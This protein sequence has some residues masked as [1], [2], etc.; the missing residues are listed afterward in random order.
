MPTVSIPIDVCRSG[1]TLTPAA[2]AVLLALLSYGGGPRPPLA[3]VAM[4]AGVSLRHLYRVMA[5]LR[6]GGFLPAETPPHTSGSGDMVAVPSATMAVPSATM[7]VPSATM[8]VPSATM[9]VSSATM[10]VSEPGFAENHASNIYIINNNNKEEDNKTEENRTYNLSV[11]QSCDDDET[12]LDAGTTDSG[13]EDPE[14]R[15]ALTRWTAH[16]RLAKWHY[17]DAWVAEY[18]RM[19]EAFP[20]QEALLE[21]IDWFGAYHDIKGRNIDGFGANTMHFLRTAAHWT[22]HEAASAVV[23]EHQDRFWTRRKKRGRKHGPTSAVRAGAHPARD[24]EPDTELIPAVEMIPAAEAEPDPAHRAE[25]LEFLRSPKADDDYARWRFD[26]EHRAG[27][28]LYVRR[29]I[30]ITQCGPAPLLALAA[31]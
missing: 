31:N 16:P 17:C 28:R 21:A 11:R 27:L 24:P 23:R 29:P 3:Q 6:A 9:A 25:C 10:A 30:A 5:T 18:F 14:A 22:S 1:V 13:D 12:P 7:A 2:K 4:D 8:A 26:E 20:A 15:E 19:R